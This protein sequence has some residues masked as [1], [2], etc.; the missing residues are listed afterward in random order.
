MERKLKKS[1]AVSL[2]C[3]TLLLAPGKIYAVGGDISITDNGDG[4]GNIEAD[5][6]FN[7]SSTNQSTTSDTNTSQE[8]STDSSKGSINNTQTGPAWNE[9]QNNAYEYKQ[10]IRDIFKNLLNSINQNKLNG[11]DSYAGLTTSGKTNMA[12]DDLQQLVDNLRAFKSLL[13]ETGSTGNSI[14]SQFNVQGSEIAAAS[15]DTADSI[16]SLTTEEYNQIKKLIAEKEN[17]NIDNYKTAKFPL[18]LG[19]NSGLI[20]SWANT[21]VR[22]D[23][24]SGGLKDSNTYTDRLEIFEGYMSNAMEDYVSVTALTD[25]HISNIN[26]QY[27]EY[28]DYE[29]D[30]EGEATIKWELVDN[31]TGQVIK[32][33]VGNYTSM[34]YTGVPAGD[35]TIRT[36]QHK[37]AT[38]YI[39]AYYDVRQYLV[40]TNTKTILYFYNLSVSSPDSRDKGKYVNIKM[41]QADEWVTMMNKNVTINGL[42]EVEKSSSGTERTK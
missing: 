39:R 13:S 22:E 5:T 10:N 24:I 36:M 20:S 32:T 9:N 15:V 21:I 42:G 19:G 38:R 8:E 34:K 26:M 3:S 18:G 27:L 14:N 7:T 30:T 1:I 2:L 40:D 4:T 12:S 11:N 31:A 41:E 6:D 16:S 17:L 29:P 28:E 37:V 23:L 25:Y 35:Y 33:D